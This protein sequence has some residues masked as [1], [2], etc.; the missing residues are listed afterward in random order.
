MRPLFPTSVGCLAAVLFA[1]TAGCSRSVPSA[2]LTETGADPGVGHAMSAPPPPD[3]A[4]AE[5][6]IAPRTALQFT[7][8]TDPLE[9]AFDT[10]VPQGWQVQGGMQR[11]GVVTSIAMTAADPA[12]G[13]VVFLGAPPQTWLFP[14]DSLRSL[15]YGIG[16]PY[17]ADGGRTH[18]TLLP[19]MEA[20]AFGTGWFRQ[21]FG[22]AEP[23]AKRPRPDLE[24]TQR[25]LEPVMGG[26]IHRVSAAD[27]DF[28]MPD[29]RF[30]TMTVMLSG[31][32]VPG[33]G[34]T[35][36]IASLY[37][38]VS[39]PDR[40]PLTAKALGRAVGALRVNPQWFFAD[41]KSVTA[42]GQQ[43]L[44]ALHESSER[45]QA[46]L[47]ARWASDDARNRQVRDLL[48]GTTRVTDRDTGEQFEV[49]NDSNH[50]YRGTGANQDTIVGTDIDQNPDPTG[51]YRRLD[52]V[53]V[54]IPDR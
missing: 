44:A 32:E 48:G 37:G 31:Q 24:A 23:V 22:S 45:Q 26:A 16:Q 47:E 40:I 43:Y 42:T 35:W 3:Q 36:R 1:L 27:V 7:R 28:R 39:P 51:D 46:A 14:T 30:A 18:F 5:A 50:Y 4:S 10:D 15:G 21:R 34:G 6:A 49:K 54:D 9:H 8:W 29:G 41:Q 53:G 11:Q 25:R 17:S 20:S 52:Q 13:S 2:S 19:F 33:V 38:F 12:S